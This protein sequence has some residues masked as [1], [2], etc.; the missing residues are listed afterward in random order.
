MGIKSNKDTEYKERVL[1]KITE[2]GMEV[3]GRSE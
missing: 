1:D 2:A 3:S